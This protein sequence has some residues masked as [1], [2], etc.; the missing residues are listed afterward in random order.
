MNTSTKEMSAIIEQQLTL[1]NVTPVTIN[2]SDTTTPEVRASSLNGMMRFWYEALNH[3]QGKQV[4]EVFG[5]TEGKISTKSK[6]WIKSVESHGN[7]IE[8]LPLSTKNVKIDAFSPNQSWTVTLAV[9]KR[10]KAYLEEGI[11]ALKAAVYFGGFGKRGRHGASSFM[12]KEDNITS[13]EEL[14]EKMAS[15]LDFY[16]VNYK[17]A[18]S[19]FKMA[20]SSR[21]TNK[22]NFTRL[23]STKHKNL[24][25]IMEAIRQVTHE[26]YIGE[27]S[28]ALGSTKPTFASPIHTSVIK[29]DNNQFDILISE[30]NYK[31]Q[32]IKRYQSAMQMYVKELISQLNEGGE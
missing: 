19:G 23:I 27:F 32:D 11:I 15:I 29:Y 30:T 21:E 22:W 5:S 26:V 13:R 12:T 7:Q 18:P 31:H 8:K 28:N 14:I 25:K 6:V 24:A 20:K 1:V 2:G 10:D 3:R 17:K 16:Q 9:R 4:G